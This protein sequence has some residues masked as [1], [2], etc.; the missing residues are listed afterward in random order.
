MHIHHN[1]FDQMWVDGQETQINLKNEN[2]GPGTAT[3]VPEYSGR[4]DTTSDG[5]THLVVARPGY[6]LPQTRSSYSP[7]AVWILTRS[8]STGP[9]YTIVNGALN[10]ADSELRLPLTTSAGTQ[11]DVPFS[12]GQPL[13]H[14]AWLQNILFENNVIRN[15][16]QAIKA[17]AST[18]R[19]MG[20][21]GQR[22][23]SEQSRL[24]H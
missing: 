20:P 23:D 1:V 24:W 3:C 11:T 2:R 9:P 7:S 13:C 8:P 4:V 21:P 15:S 16:P 19:T 6:K 22:H 5:Q 12:Y 18:E 17:V 14:A 10:Q